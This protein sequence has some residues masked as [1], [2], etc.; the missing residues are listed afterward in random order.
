[1]DKKEII[2][3]LRKA[4][5]AHIRWRSYAQALVSGVPL[6]E[7]RVPVIHTDCEFGR[8]YFGDG[9]ALAGLKSFQGIAVPHEQLHAVYMEIFKLLFEEENI[10]LLR[11]LI[12]KK[13]RTSES[14][15]RAAQSLLDEML[16]ISERLIGHID[17]LE[18]EIMQ[19]GEE[20]IAKLI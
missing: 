5:T 1:M 19:M 3:N 7:D 18:K 8:W 20:T 14:R 9:Q 15:K 6:E 16:R 10:G 4:K 13:G 11:R 12:G 2:A 17:S